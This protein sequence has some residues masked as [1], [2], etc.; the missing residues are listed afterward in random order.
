MKWTTA[1]IFALT[2]LIGA[3]VAAATFAHDGQNRGMGF[4][5]NGAPER[6]AFETL[7]AN[8]DGVITPDEIA[9]HQGTQFSSFDND[10]NGLLDTDELKAM[11]TARANERAAMM[12]DRMIAWADTDGDGAL[13]MDE[14]PGMT[15][16]RMAQRLDANG[17]GQITQEEYD[18]AGQQRMA[19]GQGGGFGKGERG[20]QHG[21]MNGQ[22]GHGRH[23]N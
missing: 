8:G 5:G 20:G 1:G 16:Q 2:G 19:R 17:D 12:I 9:I 18:A 3:G 10:S 13:S 22:G 6:P 11:M 7:D 4:G 15:M 21:G 14:M 23:G